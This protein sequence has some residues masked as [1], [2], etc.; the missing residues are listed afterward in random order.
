MVTLFKFLNSNPVV[1]KLVSPYLRPHARRTDSLL[2]KSKAKTGCMCLRYF[3]F[4][5][6]HVGRSILL[7]PRS[8]AQTKKPN[9]RF[10]PEPNSNDSSPTRRPITCMEGSFQKR[11]TPCNPH[12]RSS[13]LWETPKRVPDSG[14]LSQGSR[15]SQL[16]FRL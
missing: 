16:R 10:Y 9:L 5:A 13:F 15:V 4:M 7:N 11:A 12:I 1:C 3:N 14:Q 8:H 2:H 6:R